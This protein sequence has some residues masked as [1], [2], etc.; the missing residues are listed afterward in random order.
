MPVAA[1]EWSVAAER[2]TQVSER[3]GY[4]R[5]RDGVRP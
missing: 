3:D 4:G 2:E 1:V 5:W